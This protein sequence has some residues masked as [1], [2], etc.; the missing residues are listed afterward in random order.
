MRWYYIF[1]M[2]EFQV[3]MAINK[4]WRQ[5]TMK[6]LYIFAGLF[7]G[8]DIVKN[9][10]FISDQYFPLVKLVTIKYPVCFEFSVVHTQNSNFSTQKPNR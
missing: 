7:F 10:I 6:L 1:K 3:A 9:S 5:N 8:N 4:P 2:A